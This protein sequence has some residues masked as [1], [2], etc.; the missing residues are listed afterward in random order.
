M[1]PPL[2]LTVLPVTHLLDSPARKATTCATSSGSPTRFPAADLDALASL[3]CSRCSSGIF[4]RRSVATKPTQ[5]AGLFIKSVKKTKNVFPSLL[6]KAGHSLTIDIDSA[7]PPKLSCP[8]VGKTFDGNLTS[9]VQC[10][11]WYARSNCH[12]SR[13]DA[14]N[15]DDSSALRNMLQSFLHEEERTANVGVENVCEVVQRDIFGCRVISSGGIVNC[16]QYVLVFH[17]IR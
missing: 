5:T 15:V 12:G 4:A 16:D 7:G 8:G 9:S 3:S 1:V 6:H 2:A 14:G 11:W 17:S 10:H 13:Y